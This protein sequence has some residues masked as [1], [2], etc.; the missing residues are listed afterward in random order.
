MIYLFTGEPDIGFLMFI[1]SQHADHGGLQLRLPIP[2]IAGLSR[3]AGCP[4]H[5]D[6]PL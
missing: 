1:K 2:V 4:I 3:F 6:A 5:D